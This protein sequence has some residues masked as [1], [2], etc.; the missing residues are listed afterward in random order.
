MPSSPSATP[1]ASLLS[2]ASRGAARVLRVVGAG[3]AGGI[4][5]GVIVG[6]LGSRL[7][8]RIVGVMGRSHYGEVT[9]QNAVVGVT[10]LDGTLNL[11]IQGVGYG[12]FGGLMYL[13]VRRWMPGRGWVKGLAFG[14]FL[15][16]TQGGLVLDGD[17]EYYRYIQAWQA[18]AMFALLFP[19]YGIVNGLVTE[20]LAGKP[21]YPPHRV[22]GI[23][24]QVALGA[25]ALL[26]GIGLLLDLRELTAPGV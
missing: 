14:V 7:L 1:A 20:R 9:H 22:V 23:V 18:Y 17:Y 16:L 8:M 4:L 24:G 12:I 3:L 21:A 2:S 6:G 5:A 26:S 10:T 25:I 19:V 11:A 15:L 13:L